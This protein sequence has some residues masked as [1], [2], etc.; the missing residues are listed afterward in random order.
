[1]EGSTKLKFYPKFNWADGQDLEVPPTDI[2][3][4]RPLALSPEQLRQMEID[5]PNWA[6]RA[7]CK[8]GGHRQSKRE[9]VQEGHRIVP[10]VDAPEMPPKRPL[11]PF[12]KDSDSQEACNRALMRRRKRQA[13]NSGPAARKA[14][15]KGNLREDDYRFWKGYALDSLGEGAQCRWCGAYLQGRNAMQAHHAADYC[16]ERLLALYRFAKK[17]PQ[18]YCLACKTQTPGRRWGLPLCQRPS[19]IGRWKFTFNMYLP[20]LL[21]YMEW[22]A[23]EQK[24]DP[25][26]GPYSNI[27]GSSS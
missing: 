9:I 3:K 13:A 24:L 7:S 20:G 23:A 6:L 25:T 15:P 26:M 14:V 22:A 27:P 11:G 21:Q 19:C 10:W 4:T 2:L 17:G 8:L 5:P 1:M 12:L 18:C 16:K